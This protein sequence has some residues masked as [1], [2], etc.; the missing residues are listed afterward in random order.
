VSLDAFAPEIWSARL[1]FRLTKAHVFGQPGVINR[2]YEGDIQ[3]AGD[4]VRIQ[5]IGPVTIG[6]YTK[7]TNIAS[8]ETLT[9]AESTLLIDQ[10]KYFNFQIDDIDKRQAQIALM[11]AAM[12]EAADGLSD[13]ADTYLAGRYTEAGTSVGTGGAPKTDL[14][15]SGKAYEHLVALGVELDQ[16]NPPS[17]G[18]WAIVPPWFYGKLLLDDRFVKAGTATSDAVLRNA[19][20]GEAAGFTILKSNNV[21]NN[22]TTYRVM[23]GHPLAWSMAE[24]IR[25]V[26]AYR[27]ESRFADALKGLHLYGAKVVRPE[28]LSVLYANVA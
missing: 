20:V 1:L 18:R 27:P 7:N 28:Q 23:A 9:D 21:S 3:N 11:D 17:D 19:Q 12:R 10:A 4:S 14:G 16:T 6:S 8:P 26:E 22:G 2:D 13:V 24:Q 15:T 25:S 5:A